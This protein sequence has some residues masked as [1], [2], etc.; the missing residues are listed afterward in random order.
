M[1][2]VGRSSSSQV[3][4]SSGTPSLLWLVVV[5]VPSLTRIPIRPFGTRE[6]FP[7]FQNLDSKKM[8]QAEVLMSRRFSFDIYIDWEQKS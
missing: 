4:V 6:N 5:W 1:S 3:G 7:R 8:L 2:K